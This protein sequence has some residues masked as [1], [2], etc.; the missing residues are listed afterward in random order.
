M[1]VLKIDK[2]I[3]LIETNKSSMLFNVNGS[4]KRTFQTKSA[5]TLSILLSV[6]LDIFNDNI[7]ASAALISKP[8]SNM[9]MKDITN[10]TDTLL[11]LDALYEHATDLVGN[12]WRQ[13]SIGKQLQHVLGVT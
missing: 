10:I 13:V 6:M 5:L 7:R 12:I 9:D 11:I 1:R 3:H 8:F 2:S 4:L